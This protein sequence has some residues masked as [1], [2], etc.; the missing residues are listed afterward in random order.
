MAQVT[1]NTSNGSAVYQ[2]TQRVLNT[3]RLESIFEKGICGS[4]ALRNYGQEHQP[5]YD[6]KE[7]LVAYTNCVT[8]AE[9]L[10]KAVYDPADGVYHISIEYKDDDQLVQQVSDPTKV[11]AKFNEIIKK[12]PEAVLKAYEERL[13]K[14]AFLSALPENDSFLKILS[15]RSYKVAVLVIDGIEL[16]DAEK[17]ALSET[18]DGFFYIK[19]PKVEAEKIKH[20]LLSQEFDNNEIQQIKTKNPNV[21]FHFVASSVQDNIPF[22][23]KEKEG[24]F[25]TNR[26]IKVKIQAPD[27]LPKLTEIFNNHFAKNQKPMFIHTTRL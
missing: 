25:T 17:Y 21:E 22:G 11:E 19:R 5:G 9:K 14:S 2:P 7:S 3:E 15:D 6:E 8:K 4:L 24:I 27:F 1:N 13:K 20:V 12:I 18:T 23:Y 26:E 10:H 16:K